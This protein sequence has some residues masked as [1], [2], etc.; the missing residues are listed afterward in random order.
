MTEVEVGTGR[1]FVSRPVPRDPSYGL[2]MTDELCVGNDFLFFL[3]HTSSDFTTSLLPTQAL[4]LL[5]LVIY[6]C[7]PKNQNY[8][9][10][11]K[12]TKVYSTFLFVPSHEI[13]I[14]SNPA[15]R[16][17]LSRPVPRDP[18]PLP[19]S[20]PKLAGRSRYWFE[21]SRRHAG[22]V[23]SAFVPLAVTTYQKHKKNDKMDGI[24]KS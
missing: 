19:T 6:R 22:V 17:R 23:S 8:S 24:S 2:V 9:N 7:S 10:F 13:L 3:W 1:V 20:R 21:Q 11:Q 15:G 5:K 16:S 14:P 12:E 4:Q 18:V